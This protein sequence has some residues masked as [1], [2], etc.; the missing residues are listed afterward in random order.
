MIYPENFENKI[1]FDKIRQM[2]QNDCRSDMGRELVG[3]MKFSDDAETLRENLNETAE[4]MRILREEEFP[5]S[6]YAD[7]RPFL[8][9]IR[10]EGLFLEVPELVAL[11]NSLESLSAIVRFFN[12]KTEIYPTLCRKAGQIRL[13]P[14]ILN[15]WML[16]FPGTAPLRITLPPNWET[17]AGRS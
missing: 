10:I 9:K 16:S 12:G 2:L 11:K 4:F 5:D 1:K 17:Y 15:V 8:R 6:Y 14:F 7:A 13:F 3:E